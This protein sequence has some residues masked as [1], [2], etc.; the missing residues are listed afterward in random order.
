M[1]LHFPDRIVQNGY[2]PPP[3][4]I[5]ELQELIPLTLGR[6]D[7]SDTI[8]AI[9]VATLFGRRA[10][11]IQF[12]TVNG[13]TR[14]SNEIC[15]DEELGSVIRWSVG[16]AVI[17]ST[18][19]A[20]FEGALLPAHIRHYLSGKLRLEVDQKFSAMEGPVD[21]AALTPPNPTTLRS[22]K[23]KRPTVQSNPQPAF[24]GA[25]PWYDVAVHGVIGPDGHVYEAAVLPNGR[26]ELEQQAV[27]IV[28][29]W[30][31]SPGLCDGKPIPVD[32]H[33]VVHFPPQ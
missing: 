26:P 6:F 1:S 22:C 32:A 14:N 31:F 17:E 13:K 3:P 8:H 7:A 9:K 2:E 33:L 24:A 11:Y 28:S 29:G 21:W 25:G 27:K 20:P 5:L 30:T 4:E 10:K 12:E 16:D 19:Y 15:V 18:D 23:Y